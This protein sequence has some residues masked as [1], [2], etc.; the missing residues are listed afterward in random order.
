MK[1]LLSLALLA[2]IFV[3]SATAAPVSCVNTPDLTV[4]GK[5]ICAGAPGL[6]AP[7]LLPSI[8]TTFSQLVYWEKSSRLLDGTCPTGTSGGDCD[9]NDALL[10]VFGSGSQAWMRLI[11]ADPGISVNIFGS[12]TSVTT[13][14]LG[15]VSIPWTP[16]E[17]ALRMVTPTPWGGTQFWFSGGGID[18]NCVNYDGAAHAIVVPGNQIPEPSTIALGALGAA[19][20]LFRFC[21]R[22]P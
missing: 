9:F 21:R 18:P 14:S 4:E 15:P 1:F 13:I 17:L 16:G 6:G 19:L 10:E 7:L 2:V 20:C 12:V 11:R 22:R 3:T 5:N 8:G